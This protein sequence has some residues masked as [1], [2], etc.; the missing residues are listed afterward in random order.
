[1]T[2]EHLRTIFRISL[3]WIGVVFIAGCDSGNQSVQ[4]SSPRFVEH[5]EAGDAQT[6]VAYGTSLSFTTTSFWFERLRDDLDRVFP[7]QATLLDR[8][9]GGVASDWGVERLD[10]RVLDAAPD[11]VFIEFA[12]N[13]AFLDYNITVAQA[14]TN[15]LNI[16]D[17]I[18]SALP[19]CEII[20][21]TM[22]PP[23]FLP[24]ENRPNYKAYYQMYRDVAR[25]RDLPLIDHEPNWD[26]ILETDAAL[27]YSYLPDAIHPNEAG[28][29]AVITPEINRRLGL[30]SHLLSPPERVVRFLAQPLPF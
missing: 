7:G 25:R 27:F 9:L 1:M 5:L 23:F 22:N 24:L 8:A 17:R 4:F 29:L 14:E 3:I 13:D 15:L 19:N 26:E 2:F 28:T 12:I 16:L 18:Q 11:V 21:M 6:I 10:I 30:E 20:L